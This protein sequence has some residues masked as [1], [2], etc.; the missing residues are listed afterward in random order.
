MSEQNTPVS[1]EELHSVTA[2]AAALAEAQSFPTVPTNYYKLQGLKYDASR[3]AAGRLIIAC[4]ADAIKEDKRAGSASFYISN[5]IKRTASG[6]L[7]REFRLYN[8]LCRVLF[9]EYV[10]DTDLAKVKVG[11]LL[12]RFLQYPIGA[13]ITETFSSEPDGVSGKK[14][15]FDAKT[16][17]EAKEYREKGWKPR[18]YVQSIGKVK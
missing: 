2:S 15:Y 1:L 5:E 13:Y 6:K 9:P 7:D 4:K 12:E 18:N 16:E 14:S 11:E 17:A 3:N 8:Q 10:N